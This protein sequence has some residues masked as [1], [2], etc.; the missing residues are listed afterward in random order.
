[1]DGENEWKSIGSCCTA[2]E[3]E[4]PSV[5]EREKERMIASRIKQ[6]DNLP[7]GSRI[8]SWTI[9]DRAVECLSR[10][11]YNPRQIHYWTKGN[12]HQK[13]CRR[14]YIETNTRSSSLND[15]LVEKLSDFTSKN[16]LWHKIKA[17]TLPLTY[18]YSRKKTSS[19]TNQAFKIDGHQ[20]V[21]D[22][23]HNGCAPL[24]ILTFIYMEDK[25]STY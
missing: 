23:S 1:M 6:A 25:H 18:K 17:C 5:Q 12:S 3:W 21:V 15:S 4:L 14:I 16:R 19:S 13:C 2:F 7:G 10:Q 20:Q 8:D 24:W 22:W 11:L 9:L